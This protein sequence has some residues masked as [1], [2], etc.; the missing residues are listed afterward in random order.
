LHVPINAASSVAAFAVPVGVVAP[1]VATAYTTE[2][3]SGHVYA[4]TVNVPFDP[5]VSAVPSSAVAAEPL[6]AVPAA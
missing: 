6:P 4:G 2:L 3:L 5:V 1:P